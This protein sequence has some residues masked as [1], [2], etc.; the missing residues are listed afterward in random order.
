VV[1]PTLGTCDWIASRPPL[2]LLSLYLK[3]ASVTKLYA[4]KIEGFAARK[5]FGCLHDA[6]KIATDRLS[7]IASPQVSLFKC[8][9]WL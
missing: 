7:S 4:E 5:S 6:R 9:S 3:K 2:Q 8:P 1:C